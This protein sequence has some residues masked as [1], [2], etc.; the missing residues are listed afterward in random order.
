MLGL[1]PLLLL[2]VLLC[3]PGSKHA[4]R[5]RALQPFLRTADGHDAQLLSGWYANLRDGS[6]LDIPQRLLTSLSACLDAGR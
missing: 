3:L 2:C 5:L 6:A 4:Q 1:Q